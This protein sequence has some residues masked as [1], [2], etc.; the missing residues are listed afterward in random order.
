MKPFL[1]GSLCP[2]DRAMVYVPHD[3]WSEEAPIDAELRREEA[4]TFAQRERIA[5]RAKGGE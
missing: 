2:V 3:R 1:Y 5:R 4:L